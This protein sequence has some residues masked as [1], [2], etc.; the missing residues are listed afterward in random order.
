MKKRF[1]RL[2]LATALAAPI[3]FN[4]SGSQ[5]FAG[6]HDLVTYAKQYIG[7][8]YKW[9]GTTPS[10]FDCSGYLTYVFN[11][12]GVELP[13]TSADQFNQGETISNE[14]LM[15][16]DLVF[17]TTYKSGPSHSG[18]YLG[19]D[20]FIHSSSKGVEISNLNS[21]YYKNR[22]LGAKRFIQPTAVKESTYEMPAAKNG[23][24]GMVHVNKK[25]NLW[26]R[27]ADN[28]LEMVRVLNPGE[29]YRVYDFDEQYGGQYNLGSQLF[30]TNM[31]SHIE[32]IP[33]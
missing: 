12:F 25:I 30:I 28:K 3:L 29:K 9:G 2:L 8:P 10:G 33:Y 32:Y 24:I 21:S 16:G 31:P 17:F 5:A 4:A 22:Y 13:R 1:A 26:K 6:E 14:D 20:E 23:Q 11:E 27:T 15:P 7:V 19:D 18:I